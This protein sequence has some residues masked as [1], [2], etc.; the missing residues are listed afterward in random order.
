MPLHVFGTASQ[1]ALQANGEVMA[2]VLTNLIAILVLQVPFV[3]VV[4][5]YL[6]AALMVKDRILEQ[7]L[8]LYRQRVMQAII[9]QMD[10]AHSAFLVIH[11][12]EVLLHHHSVLPALFQSTQMVKQ[13]LSCRANL[14]LM[15]V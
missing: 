3:Q 4:Q 7:L 5:L 14:T 11:A 6:L 2:L 8:V 10:A 13:Q 15:V 1:A 9:C 12:L